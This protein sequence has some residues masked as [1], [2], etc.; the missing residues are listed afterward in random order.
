M[1]GELREYS[2][3]GFHVAGKTRFGIIVNVGANDLVNL[4]TEIKQ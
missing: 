1:V 2:E 3:D 4:A